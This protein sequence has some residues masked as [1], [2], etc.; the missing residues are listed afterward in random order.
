MIV[1][2][3]VDSVDSYTTSYNYVFTLLQS[4][5]LSILDWAAVNS[6]TMGVHCYFV[7]V[8]IPQVFL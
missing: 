6:N 2:F 3:S 1:P 7:L 4:H 8:F 5:A